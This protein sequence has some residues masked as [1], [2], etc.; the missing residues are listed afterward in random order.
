MTSGP[1]PPPPPQ[2]QRP[3]PQVVYVQPT[4]V[5]SSS[6]ATWTLVGCAGVIIA[7]LLVF[8]LVMFLFCGGCVMVAGDAATEFEKAQ[9]R[10]EAER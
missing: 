9:R 6:A 7:I 1:S 10:I 3:Q 8:L 4:H 2:Q 5:H